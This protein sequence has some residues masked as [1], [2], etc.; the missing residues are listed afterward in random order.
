MT[1]DTG[2]A[3]QIGDDCIAAAYLSLGDKEQ[4]LAGFR[5]LTLTISAGWFDLKSIRSWIRSALTHALQDLLSRMK[6]PC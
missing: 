5:R 1:S 4:A 6:F 3:C 2:P